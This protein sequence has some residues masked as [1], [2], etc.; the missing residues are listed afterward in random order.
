MKTNKYSSIGVHQSI[1]KIFKFHF[2]CYTIQSILSELYFK[3]EL[4]LN[5]L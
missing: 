2:H 1:L 4:V 5:L 3:L